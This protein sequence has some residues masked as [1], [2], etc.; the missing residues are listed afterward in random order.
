ML[1]HEI[2]GNYFHA[3]TKIISEAIRGELTERRIQEI[4]NETG[5]GESILN[6]PQALAEGQ[7]PLLD[8]KFNTPIQ[9]HPDMSLTM[10][11]KRWL[12]TLLSD[13]RIEL[14]NP[15][16]CGLEDVAPLY[17]KEILVYFDRYGDG[18]PYGDSHYVK[19]FRS[20]LKALRQ[21]RKLSIE[22]ST[23]SKQVH[24]WRCV[25]CRLEYSPKDD[26][27]RLIAVVQGRL[28]MLNVARM[29]SCTLLG[30]YSAEESITPRAKDKALTIELIDKRNTLERAMLH[31]SDLQKET[32]R[33]THEQYRITLYYDKDDETEILIRVLSFGPLIKVVS[34][35]AF[36]NRIKERFN[37][38]RNCEL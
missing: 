10:L 30:E 2:Y 26:K 15:P 16:R 4:V 31:F 1:F 25:P 27:F 33:L 3:V 24:R 32:H 19:N 35:Q 8:E 29:I 18:D 7:W 13:A 9:N 23:Q 37:K 11:Q 36:I 28:L 6:I 5:F 20:I 14:F 17:N 38:Q 22:Y 21:R 34:P 12:K